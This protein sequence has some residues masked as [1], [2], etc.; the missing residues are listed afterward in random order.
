M[1]KVER[2]S[3]VEELCDKLYLPEERKKFEW[4]VG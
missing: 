3:A 1:I 4:L 2:R